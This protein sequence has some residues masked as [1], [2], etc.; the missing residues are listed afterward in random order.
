MT[1]RYS[2]AARNFLAAWGSYKDAFANGKIEIYSGAQPASANAAVTGTLL[3][4]ITSAS[5]ARTAEVLAT[6]NITL[7][8]GAGGS[9]DTLTV[10]G[11]DILGGAVA[12]NTSLNQTA[13][14][15]AAQINAFKANVRYSAAA[16]GAVVT[17]SALPGTGASPNGFVVARTSTTITT[18]VA[19]MAGGVTAANGLLFGTAASAVIS[20]RASQNWTGVNS[21]SGTAGYFR[22][23][24]SVADAGALDSAALF[25]REDGAIAT[26][27]SELNMTTTALVATATTTISAWDRTIN[28]L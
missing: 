12:Y 23:Y 28:T 20:K 19:N 25:I 2:D 9:V 13:T 5:G 18:T 14:D 22:L 11:V 17:I 7:T 6:G 1:L 10:N 27:G 16:V 24:G 21:N 8:G 4:T 15:V 26:S 3:C